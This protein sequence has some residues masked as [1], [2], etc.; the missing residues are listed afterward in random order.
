[1]NGDFDSTAARLLSIRL[2]RCVPNDKVEC[3]SED[4]IDEF[5]RNKLILLM[6]N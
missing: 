3:K 2:N 5:F 4:E 1:M 6:Y